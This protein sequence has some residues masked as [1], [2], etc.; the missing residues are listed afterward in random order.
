MGA[1]LKF[2]NLVIEV[3][4]TILERLGTYGA[5]I[6][7]KQK[8]L[9]SYVDGSYQF[10]NRFNLSMILGLDYYSFSSLSYGVGF[11]LNYTLF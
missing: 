11:S 5:P 6:N 10:S 9:Y 2:N 4:G 1:K 3:K 8:S 7:P